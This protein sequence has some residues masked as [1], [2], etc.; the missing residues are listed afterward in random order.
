MSGIA[1][2]HHVVASLQ[3]P[4]QRRQAADRIQ[5]DVLVGDTGYVS[6]ASVH[7]GDTSQIGLDRAALHAAMAA[8]FRPATRYGVP[9][10]M[11][12]RLTFDF[13]D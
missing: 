8:R 7:H 2:R 6:R 1:R 12:T 3:L 11:W 13:R 10:S 5:L 9:G 4:D